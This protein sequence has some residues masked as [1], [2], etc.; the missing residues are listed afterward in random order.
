MDFEIKV[1]FLCFDKKFLNFLNKMKKKGGRKEL[2]FESGWYDVL[3][4]RNLFGKK[5]RAVRKELSLFLLKLFVEIWTKII[6][7][8]RKLVK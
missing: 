5:F 4:R 1:R 8:V 3:K 2:E 6:F 7:Y